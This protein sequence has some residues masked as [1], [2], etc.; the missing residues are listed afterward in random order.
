MEMLFI[1]I[2]T[3]KHLDLWKDFLKIGWVNTVKQN[4]IFDPL[5]VLNWYFHG[6]L[7]R[8]IRSIYL[9]K[10]K[11]R[12]RENVY[13]EQKETYTYT[14]ADLQYMWVYLSVL[15]RKIWKCLSSS[16]PSFTFIHCLCCCEVALHT[17]AFT[18]TIR[19]KKERRTLTRDAYS[20][21]S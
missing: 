6:Y 15:G 10:R 19:N 16:T 14:N 13:V 9:K 5:G 1:Y 17:A 3:T 8:N 11:K 12:K 18:I 7:N 4:M 2:C 21:F 20:A